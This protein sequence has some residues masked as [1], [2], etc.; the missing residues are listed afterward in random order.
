MGDVIPPPT[1]ATACRWRNAGNHVSHNQQQ[2]QA[3]N[4]ARDKDDLIGNSS[5]IT[6]SNCRGQET[7]YEVD[8]HK[9][10]HVRTFRVL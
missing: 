2:A 3:C 4:D 6:E 8:E 1:F 7:D 10:R 9:S 5:E